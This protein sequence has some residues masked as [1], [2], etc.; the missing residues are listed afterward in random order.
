M[1]T[2]RTPNQQPATRNRKTTTGDNDDEDDND[3]GDDN[4]TC[5]VDN[6]VPGAV[7]QE[8]EIE[9]EHGQAIVRG[10]RALQVGVEAR[11]SNLK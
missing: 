1:A 7:V 3:Q 11:S 8:A 10:D 2:R 9:L 5:S 4:H 6:L